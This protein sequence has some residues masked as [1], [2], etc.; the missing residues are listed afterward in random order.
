[1]AGVKDYSGTLVNATYVRLL[2]VTCVHSLG[3]VDGFTGEYTG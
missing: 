1:M 2:S 3:C